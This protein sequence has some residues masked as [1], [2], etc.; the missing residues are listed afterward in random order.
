VGDRPG[1]NYATFRFK[2]GA[3]DEDRRIRRVAFVGEIL[4]EYGFSVSIHGDALAA[5]IEDEHSAAICRVLK[6]LGYLIIHT[7]QLDMVMASGDAVAHYRRR[8]EDHIRQLTGATA[9]PAA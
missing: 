1:E 7:R 3:A 8:I 6:V 2:G 5:R 4:E 9:P